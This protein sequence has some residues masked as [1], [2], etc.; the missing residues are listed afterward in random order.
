MDAITDMG[1]TNERVYQSAARARWYASLTGLTQAEEA[2]FA[3]TSDRWQG[4]DVLD[5]GIGGGRTCE[6]LAGQARRYVGVDYSPAM[7]AEATARHPSLDLRQGDARDLSMFADGSF[8]WTFFADNGIDA[9][10]DADR[11]RV[12]SEVRRVLKP[13]GVFLYKTQNIECAKNI[14]C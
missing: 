2:A 5:I 9:V 1:A 6:I 8:D 7:V 14:W 3:L 11:M 4:G 10:D 12:L 13:G